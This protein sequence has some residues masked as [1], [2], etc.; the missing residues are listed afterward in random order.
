MVDGTIAIILHATESRDKVLSSIASNLN[1]AIKEGKFAIKEMKGHHGN[2][3]YYC[4]IKI[5]E[6]EAIGILKKIKQSLSGRCNLLD[7]INECLEGTTLHLRLSKQKI[8]ENAL[9]LGGEDVLKITLNNV[10]KEAVLEILR[11]P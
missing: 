1:I 5:S 10:T 6:E 2:P 9:E 7:E 8:C 11:D 3:L 4:V